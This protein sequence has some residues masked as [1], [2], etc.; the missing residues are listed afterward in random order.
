L[1]GVQ[2]TSAAAAPNGRAA[3]RSGAT[4]ATGVAEAVILAAAPAEGG[5]AAAAQPWEGGT[6]VGRLLD[7]LASL[8]VADVLVVTRPELEAQIRPALDGFAGTARLESSPGLAGDLRAVAA[9]A[10]AGAGGLVVLQGDV[11]TQR[12]A[13]AGLLSDPRIGTGALASGGATGRPY[14]F[15]LRARR[16]RVVSAASPF[17]STYRSTAAFLG[18]LKVGAADREALAAVAARLA[19]LTDPEPPAPWRE[20]LERKGGTWKVAVVAADERRLALE[21]GEEPPPPRDPSLPPVDPDTVT[22]DPA[23]EEER[24]R[25]LAAAPADV[26]SLLLTG[27]V[28]RGTHVSLSHLRKLFWARPLS[29]EALA[30]A[31]EK[32]LEHDEDKVLLD[33]AVKANDGFFTTYFVSPYSKYIARWA[34]RL[35]LTPNQVT[36]ISVLIGVVAAAAFATGERWGYVAG[37]ILLQAAFT[38]DCVDGQLA[39]YTRTFSKLGAWL[40]SV[41][42]RTKEY[43]VFAG[44]A[45]G[46]ARSGDPVW[47]LACAVLTLQTVRHSIDFSYAT[48]QH[49]LIATTA[50]PPLERPADVLSARR[51]VEGERD[52]TEMQAEVPE[53]AEPSL[54]LRQRAPKEALRV[55]HAFDRLPLVFWAKKMIAFPIGERFA[56]ISLTAALFTPRTTFVVLLVWGGIAFV[57]TLAGRVLRSLAA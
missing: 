13:L 20:E 45:I 43:V 36:T 54:P 41:F 35:G 7:Q 48:A 1:T 22:L 28:R 38:T 24:R 33:S 30:R 18:V 8:G 39:R 42:D 51:V 32:I 6:L 37:A 15:R 55:W 52:E 26:A 5:A 11:L 21:R 23:D 49:Q 17:H 2:Q 29:G 44:L 50:Q 16:G 19:E 47:V 34:A 3:A 14:A 10:R 57:Y 56:A 31:A 27:L 40:D 9:F 25:R 53:V 46:A 4:P 12:E